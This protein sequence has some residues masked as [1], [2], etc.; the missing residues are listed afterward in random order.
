MAS[1]IPLRTT[2]DIVLGLVVTSYKSPPPHPV[3]CSIHGE[4]VIDRQR[5]RKRSAH[6]IEVFYTPEKQVHK[7]HHVKGEE[8][9]GVAL[10]YQ[11]GLPTWIWVV[12]LDMR[13]S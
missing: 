12:Q 3:H 2:P 13:L 8:R 4:D 11:D 6:S 1:E 7:A 10:A 9:P 5:P